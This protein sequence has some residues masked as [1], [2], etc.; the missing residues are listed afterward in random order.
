MNAKILGPIH[1]DL[2]ISIQG[3]RFEQVWNKY[4]DISEYSILKSIM[5]TFSNDF[6]VAFIINLFIVCFEISLPFLLNE[7]VSYMETPLGEDGGIRYGLLLIGLYLLS[8]TM[9]RV[10]TIYSEFYQNIIFLKV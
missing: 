9:S 1:D 10:L 7:L 4:K 3:K 6:W 8:Q 5:V 2:N